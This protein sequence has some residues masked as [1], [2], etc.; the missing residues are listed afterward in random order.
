MA[1]KKQR[2]EG[3]DEFYAEYKAAEIPKG[4]KPINSSQFTLKQQLKR[5]KE[6]SHNEEESDLMHK[7]ASAIWVLIQ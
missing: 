5:F 7:E 6:F 3:F 1:E 2:S 4:G